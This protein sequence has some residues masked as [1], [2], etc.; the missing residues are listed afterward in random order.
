M[1]QMQLFSSE[2]EDPEVIV[3]KM[4]LFL[5]FNV[6]SACSDEFSCIMVTI[7]IMSR[8]TPPISCTLDTNGYAASIDAAVE[9]YE[10]RCSHFVV[11]APV[12]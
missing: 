3:A 11:V 1:S 6:N 5:W 12:N 10:A 8:L 4:Q 2:I 9:L 7:R